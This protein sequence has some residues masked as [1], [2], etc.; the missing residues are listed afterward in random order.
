MPLYNVGD[1]NKALAPI[2][3]MFARDFKH[4]QTALTKDEFKAIIGRINEL[5]NDAGGEIATAGW[6]PGR[7]WS[8]TPFD[9]IYQK[10][11]G[12]NQS[13]AGKLFGLCVWYT[14][15]TRSDDWMSGRYEKDGRDIGSRTYFRI[16]R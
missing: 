11:A 5:I 16:N 13:L 12:K 6:L 9:P 1:D 8:G 7:N 14:V 15:A 2:P 4:M 10:A 3:R